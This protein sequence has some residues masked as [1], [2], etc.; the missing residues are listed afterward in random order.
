MGSVI[1]IIVLAYGGWKGWGWYSPLIALALLTP[2]TIVKF[3]SVNSWRAEA[4]IVSRNLEDL[5][6]GALIHLVLF[7][8]VFAT[9]RALGSWRAKRLL[10]H[11]KSGPRI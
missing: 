1:A 10:A 4:G 3:A 7:Y 11:A 5:A 8:A 6:I 9:A 2:L